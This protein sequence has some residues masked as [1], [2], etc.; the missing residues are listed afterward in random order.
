MVG[1]ERKQNET[2]PRD[3]RRPVAPRQQTRLARPTAKAGFS[4]VELIIV[5]VIVGVVAAI[6]VPRFSGASQSAVDGAVAADLETLRKAID[7]YQCEHMG[8]YP[9]LARFAEQLTQYT[10]VNGNVSPTRGGAYTYGPY[11]RALPPLRVGPNRGCTG[12]ADTAGSNV[13]WVYNEKCGHITAAAEDARDR[14]N[15]PYGE[16]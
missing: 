12:V 15:R 2:V 11:I 3:D 9:E 14:R 6:A 13:G 16:Y 8:R 4:L 7:V 5:I 1:R 10:D